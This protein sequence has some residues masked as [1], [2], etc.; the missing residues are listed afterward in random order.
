MKC[1]CGFVHPTHGTVRVNG[2]L[3][4][5]DIDFPENMG[6]IIENPSFISYMFGLR[7]LEILAGYKKMYIDRTCEK[8]LWN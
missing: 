4:G 7:N 3:I 1:I 6:V 5:K 2:K 8:K